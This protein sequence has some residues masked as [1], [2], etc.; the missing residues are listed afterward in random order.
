[1]RGEVMRRKIGKILYE[2]PVRQEEIS[3]NIQIVVCKD[4]TKG[5]IK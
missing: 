3:E 2:S 4:R 5:F 1:M